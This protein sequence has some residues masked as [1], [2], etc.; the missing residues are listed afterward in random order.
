M[1]V[2]N[3]AFMRTVSVISSNDSNNHTKRTPLKFKQIRFFAD[4]W[5]YC[6]GCGSIVKVEIIPSNDTHFIS[7][8]AMD[9]EL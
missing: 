8:S 4:G 3:A 5:A 9:P 6:N 1:K 2:R 7:I